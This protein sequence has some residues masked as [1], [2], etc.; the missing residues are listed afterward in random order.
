MSCE[1]AQDDAAYV[2]GALSPAQRIGFERH[3]AGCAECTRSV[4]EM[5]GLP[6]LLARISPDVLESPTQVEPPPTLLPALVDKARR[7][8]RRRTWLTAAL[9]AAA[10]LVVAVG[11]LAAVTGFGS[12]DRSPTAL[13]PTA[14]ASTAPSHP[15]VPLVGDVV[16]GELALTNVSW[17]TRLDLVCTYRP[18]GRAGLPEEATYTMVVRTRDGHVEQVASWRGLAGEPMRLVGATA[19]S[20]DDIAWVEV[21][22]EDGLPV[23]KLTG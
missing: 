9:S 20:R 4:R 23:L 12:E 14:S 22:T 10:A 11:V 19:A 18:G 7:A 8:Q 17:G 21:R 16:S 1:F 2:L 3:L 5:A 13:P 15:M 6:G